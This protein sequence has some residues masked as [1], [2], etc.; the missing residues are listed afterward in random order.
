MLRLPRDTCEY[1]RS[2]S[3]HLKITQKTQNSER[4]NT[5][6]KSSS[7]FRKSDNIEKNNSLK[8]DFLKKYLENHRKMKEEKK[9]IQITPSAYAL[10]Q[11]RLIPPCSKNYS[12][13][14]EKK[15]LCSML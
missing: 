3:A 2:F 14:V 1:R 15:D 4:Y 5:Q 7:F 13:F 11:K 9:G 8:S 10:Y 6:T 12:Y